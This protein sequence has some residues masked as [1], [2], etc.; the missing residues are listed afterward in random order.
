MLSRFVCSY[1]FITD[2]DF[3]IYGTKGQIV[4]HA[5]FWGATK[6]T[7]VTESEEKT[8]T[9]GY[10]AGGFEFEID[11]ASRCIRAGLLESPVMPHRQTMASMSL[12]D[13]IR[14]EIGLVYPF[15]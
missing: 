12:M 13:A 14:K 7:L 11:E 10:K 8:V 3:R 1:N 9:R 6:A 2:N 4:I 15:E 5:P